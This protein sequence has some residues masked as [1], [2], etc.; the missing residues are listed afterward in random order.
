[1]FNKG[2]EGQGLALPPLNSAHCVLER[3]SRLGSR[4]GPSIWCRHPPLPNVP[5]GCA[6]RR[7]PPASQSRRWGLEMPNEGR[8]GRALSLPPLCSARNALRRP[9]RSPPMAAAP[10][11]ERRVLRGGAPSE[12][13]LPWS[14]YLCPAMI[15]L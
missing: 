2:R 5:R 3:R 6:A 11:W 12:A 15:A 1:M 7:A 10:I 14:F 13:P 8:G 9:P 4:T